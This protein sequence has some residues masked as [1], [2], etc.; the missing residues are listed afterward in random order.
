MHRAIVQARNYSHFIEHR[1]DEVNDEMRSEV[2]AFMMT[3]HDL[4]DNL[5]VNSNIGTQSLPGDWKIK[6]E[7]LEHAM[8]TQYTEREIGVLTEVKVPEECTYE[9]LATYYRKHSKVE[10]EEAQELISSKMD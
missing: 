3:S 4:F 10:L 9:A 5:E 1:N 6:K 2:Q 8:D 7:I